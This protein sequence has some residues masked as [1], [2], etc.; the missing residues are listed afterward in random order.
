MPPRW[1]P[2]AYRSSG[3]SFNLRPGIMND[4]G[5]QQGSNRNMPAPAS[6]ASCIWDL[7]RIACLISRFLVLQRNAEGVE[8]VV[9]GSEEHVTVTDRHTG[10][11][12][13]G[14]DC[15]AARVQFLAGGG[16]AGVER[17]V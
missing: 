6:M 2:K 13:I 3:W 17:R 16:V 11:V 14:L 12:G 9:V 10:Q 8:R 1:P 15:V 4:R 5:T 7:V